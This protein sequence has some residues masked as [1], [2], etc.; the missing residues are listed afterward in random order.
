MSRPRWLFTVLVPL[1][2]GLICVVNFFAPGD[3]YSGF[4]S[5]SLPGL[6]ILPLLTSSGSP[7]SLLPFIVA[8]GIFP[9]AALGF[10]MDRLRPPIIP[11]LVIIG[12]TT[13]MLCCYGLSHYPTWE[14][15]MAK[16]GSFE[17]YFWPSLNLGLFFSTA[18]LVFAMGLYRAVTWLRGKPLGAV[19]GS[20]HRMDA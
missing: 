11:W 15:A 18:I 5:G 2:W 16:N 4:A 9:M 1:V 20:R 19:W 14:R 17:A 10:A 3:E 8:A 12:V 7:L 6:W 13:A